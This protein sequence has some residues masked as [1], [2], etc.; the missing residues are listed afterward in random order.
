NEYYPAF[1]SDDKLVAFNRVPVGTSM[2]N[3]PAAEVYLVPYNNGQGGT[4]ER[5]KAND[6][7]S[8]SGLMSPGVQNTW[9]KWAPNVQQGPDGRLY[10]WVT[11]SSTRHPK[12][13]K[14]QQLYVAGIVY[15]PDTKQFTTY[16][17]I[18]LWNQSSQANNL[19]P[20]W[21]NFQI[22]HGTT[23]PPT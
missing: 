15:N 7:P 3:Q 10:Y 19:I 21:Q 20:S 5:L 17:G 22:E 23:P 6:P 11:F 1:S 14:R 18:Y 8:C 2:Y 13:Q 12:A 4:A 16:S 9:P